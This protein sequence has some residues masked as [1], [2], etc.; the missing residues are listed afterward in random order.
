MASENPKVF[1]SY[2]HDSVDHA[3][4]VLALAEQLRTDGVEA[5]I[6]QYVQDPDEGWIRWMRNQVGQA[7]RVL[8]VFTESYQ[9]R[10]EG[11]GG[12]VSRLRNRRGESSAPYRGEPK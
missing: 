10:F 7:S 3:K 6:D 4:R 8:L 11:N 9:R 1:I 2:S 12:E 5:L